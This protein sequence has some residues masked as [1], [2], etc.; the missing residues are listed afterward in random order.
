MLERLALAITQGS[1]GEIDE[2]K[3]GPDEPLGLLDALIQRRIG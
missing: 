3:C 1:A 2:T